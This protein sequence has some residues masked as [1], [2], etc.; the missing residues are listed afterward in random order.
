LALVLSASVFAFTWTN[1]E[2][3]LRWSRAFIGWEEEYWDRQTDLVV[4]VIAQP[5]DRIK[6][7]TNYQ[8]NHPRGADLTLLVEV[9]ENKALPDRVEL[10]YRF[11]E[12]RGGGH[13]SLAKVGSR[14]FRHSI[15][16]TLNS[17]EF[18]VKGGDFVNRQPYRV[19]VVTP[20][21]IDQIVLKN[22]FPDYTR[23]DSFDSD[24]KPIRQES[25]VRGTQVSLP[26]E[27]DFLLSA[28]ANKPLVG[29]RVQT[30]RFEVSL[31]DTTATL[32]LFPFEGEPQREF[33]LPSTLALQ[34]Q[35][36]SP[37]PT[38]FSVPLILTSAA[39]QKLVSHSSSVPLPL[40]AD[41]LLRIYLED[42]DGVVN[43]EPARLMVNT[44]VDQPPIVQTELRGIGTS[45]TRKANIP[46]VGE[47]TD[48]Y[49]ISKSSFQYLIDK[50]EKWQDREFET[51][52]DNGPKQFQ[53]KRSST[54]TF[55]SFSVLPLDL[56][57][58]QRLA[59]TVHAID[60]DDINGPHESRSERYIFKIVSTDELLSLL[61]AKELNLR[62]RFEQIIREIESTQKDLILHRSRAHE[63]VTLRAERKEGNDTDEPRK[64][65]EQ[66][67]EIDMAVSVSAERAQHQVLK[68]H[69]ETK[70][71]TE[72]FRDVLDELVN[73]GVHT[74]QMVERIDD[75]IVKRLYEI[76][77]VD[78][79]KTDEAI[80]L[81]KLANEKQ[82]DPLPRIDNTLTTLDVMLMHMKLVLKEMRELVEYHEAVKT[83]KLI[84]EDQE[85][86][87]KKT[88]QERKKNLLN[89][90]RLLE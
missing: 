9:P 63:A 30:D 12:G 59:L 15:S 37:D 42:T 25:I 2:A 71:V 67:R 43:S 87:S 58:G 90:L 40:P 29:V 66:L 32:T 21:R 23:L 65:D 5:G 8:Y 38:T 69:T 14:Q 22:D 19:N 83:L 86:I 3:I 50:D 10:E 4:K 70:V 24:G 27:T 82:W 55:E 45:I 75:R 44:I 39:A 54:E 18:W 56:A 7:F 85:D 6:E 41:S 79:P 60:G 20:P 72:S 81:F 62:R 52:P 36:D 33:S 78:F 11:D 31:S 61:Y 77:S 1:D 73:N 88:K 26:M 89:K 57:I 17:F 68:N 84:I 76:N 35:D 28:T 74:A 46:V 16:G 47:I 53:L 13:L 80:G 64:I 48:D 34:N 49:G 51:S